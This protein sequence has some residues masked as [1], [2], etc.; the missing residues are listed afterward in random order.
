MGKINTAE[1]D[2]LQK[3]LDDAGIEYER[4]DQKAEKVK[5]EEFEI[6]QL[7]RK[8][9]GENPWSVICNTRSYGY[10]EGKLEF[11]DM[12]YDTEGWLSAEEAFDL[13][14]ER[15]YR[16]KKIFRISGYLVADALEKK[17]D[18][19]E[20]FELL[21][22]TT[23]MWQQLHIEESKLFLPDGEIEENCDL[24][25]LDR[26]F[27]KLTTDEYDRPIPEKGERYRHFKGKIVNIVGISRNTETLELSVVY[28]TDDN[29][30]TGMFWNRPLSMF[31]SEV[32]REKYP[33]VEQKYRFERVE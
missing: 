1:L 17:S 24:A 11:W 21:P 13:I 14:M 19:K 10:E 18:I 20:I 22:R 23:E 28:G 15:M 33:E 26:H 7:H 29:L 16:P 2:K 8:D 4:I 31:M 3:L 12:V 9:D 6:H 27:E 32:D 30:L 25:L 5:G